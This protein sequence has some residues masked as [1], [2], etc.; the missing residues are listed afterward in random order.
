MSQGIS[1]TPDR[2][3]FPSESRHYAPWTPLTDSSYSYWELQR[4]SELFYL[5]IFN[6]CLLEFLAKLE[7]QGGLQNQVKQTIKTITI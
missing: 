6:N 2:V 1:K 4:G 3:F 5:F 7:S